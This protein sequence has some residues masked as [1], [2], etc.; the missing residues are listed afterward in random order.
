MA[1]PLVLKPLVLKRV[2]MNM[3]AW[4]LCCVYP[5]VV[6]KFRTKPAHTSHVYTYI[7]VREDSYN[8]MSVE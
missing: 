6:V 4:V 3:L 5:C 8:F 2:F 7:Y 1:L